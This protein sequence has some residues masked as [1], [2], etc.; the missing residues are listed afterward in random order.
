MYEIP[1]L[2]LQSLLLCSYFID[3]LETSLRFQN[4]ILIRNGLNRKNAHAKE[5]FMLFTLYPPVCI[6]ISISISVKHSNCI[7]SYH[8]YNNVCKFLIF[9]Y[10]FLP[11]SNIRASDAIFPQTIAENVQAWHFLPAMPLML[12]CIFVFRE[13]HLYERMHGAHPRNLL[14]T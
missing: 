1:L 12:F 9:N 14:E 13:T 8:Q 3:A 11:F 10:F 2:S 5:N 6:F 7:H 4:R